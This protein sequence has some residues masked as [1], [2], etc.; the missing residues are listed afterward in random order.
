M[1]EKGF[2][3]EKFDYSQ[4]SGANMWANSMM[5]DPIGRYKSYDAVIYFASLKTASNQTTVRINWAQPMG[6]D[7]PKFVHEIPPQFVSVDN[8]YHL[9]DV[10]MV[11]TFI[12][13]YTSNEHVVEAVVE[14]LVGNSAFKG[15]NPVDPFCGLW[16]ATL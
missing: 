10:P 3:I 15:I 2:E 16:D 12:N 14:K 1:T 7:V 13:G 5:K 8:P 6:F 4:L 9:Q 11:K